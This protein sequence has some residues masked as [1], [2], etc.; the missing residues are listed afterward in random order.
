[1]SHSVAY[2]LG[3][4]PDQRISKKSAMLTPK[5]A[6]LIF[7]QRIFEHSVIQLCP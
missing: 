2:I 3:C 5:V 6:K 1:M 7:A 4:S